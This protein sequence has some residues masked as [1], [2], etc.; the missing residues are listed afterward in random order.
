MPAEPKCD[1]KT[2]SGHKTALFLFGMQYGVSGDTDYVAAETE[3]SKAIR[4]VKVTPPSISRGKVDA[5]CIED[6]VKAQAPQGLL[7]IG[8]VSMSV[9][10]VEGDPAAEYYKQTL[11]LDR[12]YGLWLRFRNGEALFAKVFGAKFE[13]EEISADNIV[14]AKF[15]FTVANKP[16]WALP[17]GWPALTNAFNDFAEE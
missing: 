9:M 12:Y 16:V 14:M 13:V 5:F 6:T 7:E 1:G 11:M 8:D 17:N 4:M 15:D 2:L 10:Y 3:W